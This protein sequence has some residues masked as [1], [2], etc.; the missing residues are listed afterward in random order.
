MSQE[1]GLRWMSLCPPWRLYGLGRRRFVRPTSQIF[2]KLPGCLSGKEANGVMSVLTKILGI[3]GRPGRNAGTQVRGS[4]VLNLEEISI[5]V[6]R[7]VV[8]D[9][10]C[11][12]CMVG[13]GI[14]SGSSGS[15]SRSIM[16]GGKGPG[17]DG[18]ELLILS[19]SSSI[20]EM[21]FASSAGV[22]SVVSDASTFS[23]IE[24]QLKW[25]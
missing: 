17:V 3:G 21:S 22:V 18:V 9:S 16:K 23:R 8:G 12:V 20:L 5:I 24:F 11:L 4:S 14:G 6:G 10:S 2:N 15:E 25:E 7:M 13:S 19:K 1:L